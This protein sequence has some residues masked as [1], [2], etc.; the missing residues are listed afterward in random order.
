MASIPIAVKNN[1]ANGFNRQI[2]T[3]GGGTLTLTPDEQNSIDF[4]FKKDNQ[5]PRFRLGKRGAS[6][7]SKESSF[8]KE[9]RCRGMRLLMTVTMTGAA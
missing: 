6:A 8:N 4:D 9:A 3:S 2:M 1:F 5:A 7:R